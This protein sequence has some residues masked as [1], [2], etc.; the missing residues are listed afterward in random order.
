MFSFFFREWFWEG[1]HFNN[2]YLLLLKRR[3]PIL[4]L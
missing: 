3:V 1:H 2:I 4:I